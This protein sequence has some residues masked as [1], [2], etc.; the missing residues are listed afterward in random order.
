[1]LTFK[2]FPERLGLR[3]FIRV[4]I[5]HR[6]SILGSNNLGFHTNKVTLTFKMNNLKT[7]VRKRTIL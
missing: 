4:Y 6:V 5:F 3:T 1:M 2:N 7:I